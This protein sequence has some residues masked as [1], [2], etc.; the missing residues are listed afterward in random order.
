VLDCIWEINNGSEDNERRTP[1]VSVSAP[2]VYQDQEFFTAKIIRKTVTYN[3]HHQ[4][5]VFNSHQVECFSFQ[6][7]RIGCELMEVSYSIPQISISQMALKKVNGTKGLL[8]RY[9]FEDKHSGE[10]PNEFSITFHL[11]IETVRN[12]GPHLT[13]VLWTNQLW[14]ATENGLFTDVDFVVGEETFH[15]HRFIVSARSP[16]IAA[17][18][19]PQW[20]EGK[21]GRVTIS[22]DVDPK[23][24][25]HFL[26]FLYTGQVEFLALLNKQLLSLADQYDVPLLKDLCLPAQSSNEL[27]AVKDLVEIVFS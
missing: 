6:L 23:T 11:K 13:D 3:S 12:F 4:S 1:K 7:E 9:V 2:F 18:L 16:V 27:F 8:H 5:R 17:M 25:Q 20:T 15:A 10:L 22:N 21:T 26:K 19:N 24:F 14:E